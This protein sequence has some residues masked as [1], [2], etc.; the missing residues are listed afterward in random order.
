MGIKEFLEELG[1]EGS[2]IRQA[3]LMFAA[4]CI[5]I[6]GGVFGVMQLLYK[7]TLDNK[8][9]LIETLQDQ[10]ASKPQAASGTA[11]IVPTNFRLFLPGGNIFIPNIEPGLTGIA[12]D[13]TI[14]NTGTPSLALDWRLSVIPDVGKPQE[15]QL[16]KMP[17]SLVAR[18]PNNTAHL[19]SSEALDVSTLSDPLQTNVPRSGK[20]LFYV[21][22]PKAR[23][24]ESVLEL[25]VTDNNG[26]RYLVRQDIKQWLTR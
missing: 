14:V 20:L 23:V 2:V 9:D 10:L 16:T 6:V 25:T 4:A 7:T 22:M 5:V 17:P 19:N 1:R 8:S 3:P 11:P 15:A 13:A 21:K 18:G 24:M 26:T 12:L